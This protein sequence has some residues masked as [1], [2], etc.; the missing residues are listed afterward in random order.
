VEDAMEAMEV[1][2]DEGA[3]KEEKDGVETLVAALEKGVEEE[4]EE[5]SEA[6]EKREE[7]EAKLD[8][9]EEDEE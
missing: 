3:A 2:E 6:E 7:V 4:E 9:E 5:S 1:K 8:V